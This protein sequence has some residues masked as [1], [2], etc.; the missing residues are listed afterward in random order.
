MEEYK[1][2][3]RAKLADLVKSGRTVVE[4]SADWCSDCR[5]WNLPC[6]QSKLT[7]Q[8]ASSSRSTGTALSTCARK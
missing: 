3:D 8:T 5:F 4:F 2:V 1:V 6:Q 7:S